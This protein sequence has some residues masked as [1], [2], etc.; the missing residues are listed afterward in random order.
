VHFYAVKHLRLYVILQHAGGKTL[1]ARGASARKRR[2]EVLPV[3]IQLEGGQRVLDYG[4]SA[5]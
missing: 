4:K 1:D 2:T 5:T 3:Y